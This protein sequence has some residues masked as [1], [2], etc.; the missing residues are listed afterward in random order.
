MS[1]V[2][3]LS[4]F[5]VSDGVSQGEINLVYDLM[6]SNLISAEEVSQATGIPPSEIQGVYDSIK[7]T[8]SSTPL[9]YLS[10]G[11]IFSGT[12]LPPRPSSVDTTPIGGSDLGAG[13]RGFDPRGDI[14]APPGSG[15]YISD[16]DRDLDI[17]DERERLA[18]LQV[19]ADYLKELGEAELARQAKFNA[20]RLA[21]ALAEEAAARQAEAAEAAA[22]AA[23]ASPEAAETQR[24]DDDFDTKVNAA[25]GVTPGTIGEVIKIAL[26]VYGDDSRGVVKVISES[27]KGGV[28]MKDLEEATDLSGDEILEAA[29]T[30]AN[31]PDK[32][33]TPGEILSGAANTVYDITNKVVD[34]VE[35]GLE[36]TGIE[37]VID[38]IGN[39]VSKIVGLDPSQTQKVLVVN[40]VTGQVTVQASNQPQ[41]GILGS[42][43][44]SPYVPIGT[45]SGGTTYGIDA[46]NAIINVVLGK[47]LTNGGLDQGDTKSVIAAGVE[48]VTGIPMEVAGNVIDVAGAVIDQ[49]GKV[50]KDS[51]ILNAAEDNTGTTLTVV[52][53]GTNVGDTS[54]EN[55]MGPID[56]RT[57]AEK[58][59]D[60]EE[61]ANRTYTSVGSS[62]QDLLDLIAN[63]GTGNDTITGGTGND[64]ITGGTGNDTIT[65]GTGN[66]TITGGTGNDTS[67][68]ATDGL[69][70]PFQVDEDGNTIL[71]SSST[72]N[73]TLTLAPTVTANTPCDN[74]DEVRDPV[75]LVCAK[76]TGTTTGTT[77]GT[78]TANTPC[79]NA[80]E[81]RDPVTLV[82]AK[83][84]GTT[85]GTTTGTIT[86]NTPCDNADEVRD[87]VT[88]VCAKPT[89]TTTG[90]TTG[91]ITASTPC[92][93]TGEVRDPVTLVCGK[94]TGGQTKVCPEGT[95]L[96]RQTV[97]INADCGT[98][99]E[100]D[101]KTV[102]VDG[103]TNV[104]NY[105]CKEEGAVYNPVTE[106]CEKTNTTTLDTTVKEEVV[107]SD[108]DAVYDATLNNGQGGCFKINKTSLATSDTREEV[109][110]SD[111]DAVYDATLN[112]GQGG[113]FKTT[114]RT[115][116][117]AN[118]LTQTIC[119]TGTWDET[120]QKCVNTVTGNV[121]NKT[122]CKDGSE[123]D[124]NG[125]CITK[126]TGNTLT[127]TVC[128]EGTWDETLQKCVNTVTGNV[129]NKTICKDGSEP[130]A[131]GNC[132][133]KVT[134]NTLTQTVCEEGTW[135]ETLQKCVNTVT[136]NVI[137]KT[138]CKDGSEPDANG[139]CI[140]KVTGNTLTQTVCETGT[141]DETLQKCVNTVTGDVI[142]KT[143][144][145][146]GSK[147]DANGNCII[148]ITLDTTTNTICPEGS[149][150]G[151]DNRCYNDVTGEVVQNNVCPAGTTYNETSKQC[152]YSKYL[153]GPGFTFNILTSKCEPD[154]EKEK[155]TGGIT[156]LPIPDLKVPG[157]GDFVTADDVL[158][159]N[160]GDVGG[161]Y[162]ILP[163]PV[164][165]P[166]LAG[167]RQQDIRNV[168]DTVGIQQGAELEQDQ[169]A[170]DRFAGY[171][172]AFDVG[173]PEL[174]DISGVL[175]GDL[176]AYEEKFNV[177]FP[178]F[179]IAPPVRP[180][181]NLF[182]IA[183]ARFDPTTY[184]P[185]AMAAGGVV[186]KE[187]GIES[188][189]D[190]RQQAVN[191]MLI[192]RAGSYF[193]R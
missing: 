119:E 170:V 27:L 185:T 104:V 9:N 73:T 142:N 105:I 84:T 184:T 54:F 45:T 192:K 49:T 190:R 25:G 171:A 37:K 41:G 159:E 186:E 118:T 69:M 2:N 46:E 89:G 181:E 165:E 5:D 149:Y 117:G 134:G 74:A 123:P 64:T 21:A 77:T 50:I 133:T 145:K 103:V 8:E 110:C 24:K 162:S 22:Q 68:S 122:I 172:N 56:T 183:G 187:N 39:T 136:G 55:I 163:A 93:T 85:T 6:N 86:A 91:T 80:D 152:E 132:I 130:D 12:G 168:A 113:C 178:E 121:I 182:P 193:G 176:P 40:P 174:L 128:E 20:D 10:S 47:I 4:S 156:T 70:G 43:P 139:N 188:L 116:E 144:C 32:S 164:R 161:I 173:T 138:I 137:N 65:G 131:N 60:A 141:W 63:S 72:S 28:T 109:V 42:L 150:K 66:D 175:P 102:V 157:R 115:I 34:I 82:C 151:D 169:A 58:A 180:D 160:T 114:T 1:A 52:P 18:D 189:M 51:G 179:G 75:T 33:L 100:D 120:L 79:D 31:D 83:P 26:E 16:F 19:A 23:A 62:T 191:R 108:P 14:F 111:P 67:T 147:P 94:P 97:D 140:T 15:S 166:F 7:A 124:A 78:I 96:A 167:R 11:N 76:P 81:V 29:K 112:N 99:D 57:D 154:E 61:A 155:E 36:V 177:Q 101:D 106:R 146:D 153:C 30:A 90:T 38:T 107:C 95:K 88:L 148:T 87:P 143:I 17:Q 125:N 53:G 44:Q 59:A 135:D 71:P 3:L 127:Q 126:V 92:E 48:E 98:M 13:E 129:I 35:T 158:V